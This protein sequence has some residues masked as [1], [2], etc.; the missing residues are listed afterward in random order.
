MRIENC[1]SSIGPLSASSP[2]VELQLVTIEAGPR[3]GVTDAYVAKFCR[4]LSGTIGEGE[5]K[6]RI[7]L[8][9]GSAHTEN[10]GH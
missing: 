3:V 10:D 6:A 5:G 1:C 9:G 8:R 4:C 7:E 2:A